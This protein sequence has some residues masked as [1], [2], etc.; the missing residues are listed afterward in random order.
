MEERIEHNERLIKA[1]SEIE[2][3]VTGDRLS[4]DFKQLEKGAGG[5]TAD[6]QL[7][8]LKQKMGLLAGGTSAPKKQLGAGANQALNEE[9]VHAEIEDAEEEK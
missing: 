4:H 5:A 8:A 6:M 7:L 1:S 2:E 9:T 3:E